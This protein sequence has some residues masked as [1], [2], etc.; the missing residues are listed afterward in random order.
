MDTLFIANKRLKIRIKEFVEER[1]AA[2]KYEY[3]QGNEVDDDRMFYLRHVDIIMNT[4]NK[5]ID[6]SNRLVSDDDDSY[7]VAF[8]LL[9]VTSLAA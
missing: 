4:H 3:R 6:D 1:K 9:L 2:S 5:A 8:L 7:E